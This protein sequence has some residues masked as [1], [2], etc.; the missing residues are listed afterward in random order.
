MRK[1]IGFAAMA[2]MLILIFDSATAFSGAVQGVDLCIRTVIPALFPFILIC[3]WLMN[4]LKN[5]KMPILRW[6]GMIIGVPDGA[7]MVLLPAFLGGYPVG[8]QSVF[9]AYSAGIISRDT[10]QKMLSFCSNVG[11]AFI[12]GMLT[13]KFGH[14]RDV[15]LL[16]LIQ[17]SSIMGVAVLTTLSEKHAVCQKDIKMDERG[18]GSAI[19]AMSKICGWVVF[20]KVV[21]AI[22]DKRVLWRIPILARVITIG[23]LELTNG[24][25]M[26]GEIENEAIRFVVC[27]GLLSFGG[28]C[29][30]AQTASVCGELSIGNYIKGKSLQ[31]LFSVC[32]SCMLHFSLWY[33]IPVC[34]AMIYGIWKRKE[35]NS[36]NLVGAV[37]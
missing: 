29:V 2:G 31:T 37:V 4:G 19:N 1:H 8:A 20:F 27:S 10:A 26:L 34:L 24:C 35:K 32:L 3:S 7:E 13:V 33:G 22:I 21:T 16:W 6:L 18:M 9:Q 11:P 25:A 5:E 12:F 28:I 17:L 30:T 23:L 36:R 14:T 15:W